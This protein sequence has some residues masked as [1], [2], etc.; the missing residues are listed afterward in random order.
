MSKEDK[1]AWGIPS[2]EMKAALS[3]L[4]CGREALAHLTA[5][6]DEGKREGDPEFDS[7]VISCRLIALGW[8]LG[9]MSYG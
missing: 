6:H 2:D 1:D 3:T 5:L 7:A 4:P 9:G 8:Y